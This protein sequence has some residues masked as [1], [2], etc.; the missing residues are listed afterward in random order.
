MGDR[1]DATSSHQA[2]TAGLTAVSFE[3][4]SVA[5]GAGTVDTVI[6]ALTDMQGRLQ[7]KRLHGPYFVD[8]VIGHGTEACS[9]LLAVDIDM[10][11]V[12]GYDLTS[13]DRGYGD[14]ELIPDPATVRILPWQE[15]TALV[16]A[17]VQWPDGSPWPRRRG[18]CSRGS[19]PGPPSTAGPVTRAPSWSSSSSRT[20]TRRRGP[21][22][23]RSHP[24][25]PVQRR[26]LGAGHLPSRAA[27]A[28]HP[29]RHGR[30]RDDGRVGQGRMQPRAAR[31][32]VP[33]DDALDHLRSARI[34]KTGA[35]EIA[36][37]HGCSLTF[38]A[39]LNDKEGTPATSTCRSGIVTGGR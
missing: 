20:P 39:K 4:I 32:R 22:L 27:A 26:L 7:G 29:A 18:R 14:F 17:D 23:P 10:N 19:W 9:Y 28:R 25:Q 33:Y 36:A 34:Y 16:L 12:D 13:W 1:G 8:Q 15:R 38:M 31:D 35:K 21:R 3:A 11:T 37:A 6:V 30:G 2:G 5:V 24:G